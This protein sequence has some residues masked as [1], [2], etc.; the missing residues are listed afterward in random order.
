MKNI[1]NSCILI[2]GIALLIGCSIETSHNLRQQKLNNDEKKQYIIN[3]SQGGDLIKT[4]DFYGY[5]IPINNISM[6]HI[7]AEVFEEDIYP[8]IRWDTSYPNSIQII[9]T[10]GPDLESELKKLD[11]FLTL[12]HS[13]VQVSS[14]IKLISEAIVVPERRGWAFFED[15]TYISFG[16]ASD[17]TMYVVTIGNVEDLE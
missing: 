2:V 12:K 9:L 16:L 7:I 13:E 6:D 5:N 1:K 10:I 15:N 3:A 14:L 4:I 8:I 17:E 11:N